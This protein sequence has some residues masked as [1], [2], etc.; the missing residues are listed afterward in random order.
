VIQHGN[1]RWPSLALAAAATGEV[2]A[3][4][5]ERQIVRV[6]TASDAPEFAFSTAERTRAD[7]EGCEAIVAGDLAALTLLD[8]TP[9]ASLRHAERRLA[10]EQAVDL[11]KTEELARL[12]DK[13][14]LVGVQK[15]GVDVER[16]SRGGTEE[17]FG[18]ELHAEQLNGLLRG[19]AIRPLPPVWQLG[20]MLALAFAGAWF[21]TW[22]AGRHVWLRGGTALGVLLAYAAL[23]VFIYRSESRL[24]NVPYDVVAFALGW[25]GVVWLRKRAKE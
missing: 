10:Y 25:W 20:V 2:E 18:I 23:V 17:R 9:L 24:M 14:V 19:T 11:A 5:E 21:G 16:I 4:D 3:L 1:S 8:F 6:R 12:R 13:I 22:G 7:Q 15:P